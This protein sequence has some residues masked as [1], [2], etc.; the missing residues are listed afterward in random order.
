MLDRQRI[1]EAAISQPGQHISRWVFSIWAVSY[2]RGVPNNVARIR[3]PLL[4]QGR[5]QR[6][7]KQISNSEPYNSIIGLAEKIQAPS[8]VRLLAA[9]F[10]PALCPAPIG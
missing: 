10:M 2:I 5:R 9:T 4:F 6:M 8:I 7:H 3:C 1:F